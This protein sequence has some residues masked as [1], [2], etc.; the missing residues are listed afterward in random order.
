MP[1]LIPTILLTSLSGKKALYDTVLKQAKMFHP[2]ARVIGA[3]CNAN[4]SASHQIQ[5]FRVMP[6]LDLLGKSELLTYLAR[7]NVTHVLPTRDGELK[8]WAQ[9]ADPLAR[10]G[11]SVLISNFAAINFCEDKLT[12]S[13]QLLSQQLRAIPSYLEAENLPTKRLVIKERRSSGSRKIF[14]DLSKSDALARR[15]LFTEPI[16]QPH[17]KGNE[18]TAEA[19]LNR[20]GI[21]CSVILRWRDLVINGESHRSTVFHNAQ[22]ESSISKMLN[23]IKGLSGHCISQVIVDSK[24]ELHLVEVNPRLGGASP[25]SLSAGFNSIFWSLQEEV[26]TGPF[27][28]DFSPLYGAKLAKIRGQVFISL[29]K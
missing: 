2:L 21:T 3:D 27:T 20:K 18:F 15:T 4:C 13:Q 11:I 9:M 26:S 5:Q 24:Q 28:P 25:L 23:S 6:S 14:I 17:I 10:H 22:W 19:W 7:L 12:F 8:Y 1:E 16:Y 29:P